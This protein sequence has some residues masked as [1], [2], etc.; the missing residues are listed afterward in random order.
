MLECWHICAIIMYTLVHFYRN[1][2]YMLSFVTFVTPTTQACI[3]RPILDIFTCKPVLNEHSIASRTLIPR[4]QT[5][6]QLK[7]HN[8]FQQLSP[9][10]SF[11][12]KFI[13]H[14]IVLVS[15]SQKGKVLA[16]PNVFACWQ[17]ISVWIY[18]GIFV[19][20]SEV[21]VS[22]HRPSA[23]SLKFTVKILQKENRITNVN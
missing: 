2:S 16:L 14:C 10:T 22:L 7:S 5:T 1:N 17:K 6:E 11:Q 21:R 4:S 18:E 9:Q 19:N 15:F 8:K 23:D 13:V 3:S 12:L 20:G